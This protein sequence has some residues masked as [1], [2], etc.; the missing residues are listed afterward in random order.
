[1]PTESSRAAAF[2]GSDNLQML[3]GDPRTAVFDE[4]L[5]RST[6]D[7]GHLKRWPLHQILAGVSRLVVLFKIVS[8]SSG[9]TAALKC[10]LDT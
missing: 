1:M 2:D 7:I 6:D 5:S 10:R 3:P 4:L 8:E 9:L